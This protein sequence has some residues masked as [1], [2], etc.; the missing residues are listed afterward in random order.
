[1]KRNRKAFILTVILVIAV[2]VVG[3]VTT[4]YAWFLSRYSKDYP[5]LLESTSP[6]II[7]YE[8]DLQYASGTISMP[9]NVLIPA[10]A[11][12]PDANISQ[13]ALS[14]MDVF[15]TTKVETS[16]QAVKFTASGA[17]WAGEDNTPGQ[18]KP[19]LH[20]YTNT[21]MGSSELSARL[22]ALSTQQTTYSS[23]TESNLYEVLNK[24][25]ITYNTATDRLIARNDL[26]RQGEISFVMVLNYLNETF[27]YYDGAF[28]VSA[29]SASSFT[30]PAA[31]ESDSNLRYWQ[32]L[33]TASTVTI[34]QE[35]VPVYDGEYFLLQPNT[36]FTFTMYVFIAKTDEELDPDMN[37]KRLS[38]FASLTVQE[39]LAGGNE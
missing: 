37:G 19:E 27:L 29:Q 22:S 8:S 28:Y 26:V 35:A 16:A 38:L 9:T 10:T 24:E 18:F 17:Y 3:T 20:A 34:G 32:A 31:M 2:L 21:F 4:T 33:T 11:K 36:T 1:M 7:K 12:K 30:L 15:D 23:L 14:P 5:F 39:P 6:L 25:A 13:P